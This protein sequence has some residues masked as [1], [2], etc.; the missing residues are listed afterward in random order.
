MSLRHQTRSLLTQAA[1][2]RKASVASIDYRI[3]AGLPHFLPKENFDRISTWQSGLWDRLLSEVQTN[4][5]LMAVREK[6]DKSSV[7]VLDLL[8]ESAREPSQTLAFNYASLLLNNSF[9]LE[10]LAGEGPQ[11]PSLIRGEALSELENKAMAFSEGIVGGAWLWLARTGP[12]PSDLDI[13]PTFSSGTLLVSSRQQ[14]G[15]DNLPLYNQPTLPPSSSSD[16]NST[17]APSA[18][19]KKRTL[20]RIT[21]PTPLAVLNLYEHAYLSDKYDVWGKKAYTRDWWRSLDWTKIEARNASV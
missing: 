8:T 17:S 5:D 9:F 12:N 21:Y 13:I 18:P 2:S 15:R 10:G 19:A 3:L 4:P 14:K 11:Q 1:S 16:P 7:N 6:W 20:E